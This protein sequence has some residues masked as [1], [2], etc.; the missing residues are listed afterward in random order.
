[1]PFHEDLGRS[2]SLEPPDTGLEF[3]KLG[4][5]NLRAVKVEV[6]VFNFREVHKSSE[7]CLDHGAID[8]GR[9]KVQ[10]PTHSHEKQ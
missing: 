4:E 3:A 9:R 6:D 1:M 7:R 2:D 10:R 8:S 5:A